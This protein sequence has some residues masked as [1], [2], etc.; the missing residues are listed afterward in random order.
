MYVISSRD[1]FW[2]N[3]SVRPRDQ[4]DQIKEIRYRGRREVPRTVDDYVSKIEGKRV[5][6]LCHGYNN[7]RR[8]V[9]SLYFCLQCKESTLIKYFDVVVGYTWPASVGGGSYPAARRRVPT[10]AM[11]FAELLGTTISA[12]SELGVLSHSM[13][14]LISLMAHDQLHRTNVKKAKNHWQFLMAASVGEGSIES[15]GEHFDATS[16]CDKTYVFFS[17]KDRTLGN[18]YPWYEKQSGGIEEPAL[19]YAGPANPSAVSGRTKIINCSSVVRGHSRYKE[20]PEIYQYIGDE[21]H[22]NYPAPKRHVLSPSQ[23]YAPTVPG[24]PPR[25]L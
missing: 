13:G 23:M 10:V 2:C 6:L 18:W 25:Q 1:N 5:L 8:A 17:E 3:D 19:G 14:C 7:Q 24:G 15:D 22:K 20:T 9:R 21:L 16:Y 4:S 11:R 12:C